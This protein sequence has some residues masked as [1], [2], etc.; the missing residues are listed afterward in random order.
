MQTPVGY[1]VRNGIVYATD[2]FDMIFNPSFLYHFAHRVAAAYL[3][4]AFVVLAVGTC[5]LLAGHHLVDARIM[6]RMGIGL[7]AGTAPDRRSARAQ[8]FYLSAD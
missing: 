8:N 6:M 7:R 3:T 5:Y 2:W 4:M 1:E